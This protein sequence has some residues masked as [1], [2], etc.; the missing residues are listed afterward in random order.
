MSSTLTVVTYN[1]QANS[2]IVTHVTIHTERSHAS[3][4]IRVNDIITW[5]ASTVACILLQDLQRTSTVDNAIIIR[6]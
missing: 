3:F 2:S 1:C 4:A 6:W 5:R